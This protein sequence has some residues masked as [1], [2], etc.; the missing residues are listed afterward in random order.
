VFFAVRVVFALGKS[1]F[2]QRN[3]L[4]DSILFEITLNA[5]KCGKCALVKG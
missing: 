2:S 4:R 3:D 5:E 1:V